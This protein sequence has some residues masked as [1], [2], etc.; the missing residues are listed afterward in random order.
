MDWSAIPN[1]AVPT[2][3]TSDDAQDSDRAVMESASSC[4]VSLSSF[5]TPASS[6]AGTPAGRRSLSPR[7]GVSVD[8]PLKSQRKDAAEPAAAMGPPKPGSVPPKR[9]A[10]PKRGGK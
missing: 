9:G 2:F 10:P 8:R 6:R 5:D 7:S 4:G 3:P 1:P